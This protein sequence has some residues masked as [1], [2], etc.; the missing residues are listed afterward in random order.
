MQ[1]PIKYKLYDNKLWVRFGLEDKWKIAQWNVKGSR[2]TPITQS[3]GNDFIWKKSEPSNWTGRYFYS[4]IIGKLDGHNGIDFKTTIESG[5]RLYAPE[6]MEITQLSTADDYRVKAKS[7]TGYHRFLHLKE[8]HCSVGQKLKQGEFFALANF[9]GRYKGTA[10]HLHWDFKPLNYDI[11]NGYYG[12]IDQRGFIEDLEIFKLPYQDGQCLMR[13]EAHGEFY[14]VEGG[15]LVYKD[16]DKQVD[17]HIPI[18]DYFIKQKDKGL[19]K[20]FIKA[21]KEDEFKLFNQ[22]IK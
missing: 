11:K 20:G 5:T 17:R 12:A 7:A 2:Y 9:S 8:F 6:D 19:P 21:I 3:F 14:V 13:T 15:D 18:V 4:D 1:S 10:P 22:L 16:S